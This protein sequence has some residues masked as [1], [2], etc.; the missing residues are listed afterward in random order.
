[1]RLIEQGIS[2]LFLIESDAHFDRRGAFRRSFCKT[3]LANNGINFDVS[4]GN[5]SE[6]TSKHTLRGFHYQTPPY[7]EGKILECIT[8]SIFNVVIDLREDSQTYLTHQA[9]T[10]SSEAHCSLLVPPGCAN[11][12][13]TLE[14]HTI[15][16]YYMG[17]EF[18]PDRYAG[19]R[20]NDPFFGVVWPALPS[21]ISD[22]D[23]N[24]PD[25]KIL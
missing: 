20:F 18:V 24:Y 11:G 13:L 8:G 1:M 5:I 4:Q 12:F 15:V 16:H 17:C 7:T 10:V 25:F 3:I 23:L 22:R 19:F 21:V 9:V 6:N 14:D 2:G